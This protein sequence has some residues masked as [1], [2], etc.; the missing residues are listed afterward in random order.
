MAHQNRYGNLSAKLPRMLMLLVVATCVAVGN[1][2]SAAENDLGWTLDSTLKQIGRQ[3]DNFETLLADVHA[4]SE[5]SDGELVR[6][7]RGRLYMNKAGNIRILL[8]GTENRE[9]L[10]TRSEVQEYNPAQALVE[11]YSISKHPNRMEPYA[12]LGFTTTGK[13]LKDNFLV[14]MIGEDVI[15]GERVLGLELTPKKD[16]VRQIVSKVT[17]W[18]NEA[19]WMP[20]RQ[21]VEHVSRQET[22]TIEYQGAARNLKLNPDLFQAKWPRG[23][24]KVWR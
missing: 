17:L 9:I 4:R 15:R 18:F 16:A 19:S 3:G 14:T 13:D 8:E 22:L 24:K 2:V 23:T 10:V 5:S 12:R 21:V 1:H 11:R 6:E 20:V 7:A